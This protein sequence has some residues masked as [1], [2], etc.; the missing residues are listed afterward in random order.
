MT[1]TSDPRSVFINCPFDDEY[2][3]LFYAMIFTIMNCEYTP[4][5][6]YEIEDGGETRISKISKIIADC[7][8]GIHDI[9]RTELNDNDLPRFNMPL[10]LGMFLG[11][12]KYGNKDQKKKICLILDRELY[13]YAIYISDIAGQDIRSHGNDQLVMINMVRDWLRNQSGRTTLIGGAEIRRRY[14]LFCADLPSI[15]INLDLTE[16]EL[17]YKDYVTIIATW[18][19]DANY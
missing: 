2:K 5:C 10:E 19:E 13:R 3:P 8:Y 7:R 4:R 11:A 1:T 6:S 12:K 15:C 17:I 14:G 16:N 18:L 9:S